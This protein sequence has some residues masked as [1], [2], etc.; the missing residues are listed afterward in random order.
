MN[1]PDGPTISVIIPN[2]NHQDYLGRAL[3][4][5]CTQDV[6]P[7]EVLVL[8]DCST[9]NSLAVVRSFQDRF[10][11]VRVLRYPE[12]SADWLQA[13]SNHLHLLRGD[14]VLS[15]GADDAVL[16]GFFRAATDAIRKYPGVGV[17]FTNWYVIDPRGQVKGLFNSGVS[18]ECCLR[19]E[20]LC[21]QLCRM[22]EML[23]GQLFKPDL[24]ECGVGSVIRRD[25]MVWL[26]GLRFYALGPY[27]D[28]MGYSVAALKHGA[29]YI[30]QPFAGFTASEQGNFHHVIYHETKSVDLY[31]RVAQFFR[32][33]AVQPFVPPVVVEALLRKIMARMPPKALEALRSSALR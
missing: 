10:P 13:W 11:F 24:F 15:L 8:D 5:V 31:H 12:K 25:E 6:P 1:H 20:V 2:Y 19:G 30:P 4:G 3:N 28:S 9:D 29:A 26:D 14:Y 27:C 16:P 32:D 22:G 18:Y 33:P 23:P 17:V 7:V 21:R